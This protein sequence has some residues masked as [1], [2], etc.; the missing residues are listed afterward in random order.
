MKKLLWITA[1]FMAL[2]LV[3]TGCEKEAKEGNP[4]SDDE[5]NLKEVFT[6]VAVDAVE[7]T[8]T[9]TVGA[10]TFSFSGT[11]GQETNWKDELA[12]AT[13]TGKLSVPEGKPF[14]ASKYTGF[15]FEFK[16]NSQW[17]IIIV[18]DLKGGDDNNVWIYKY[19]NSDG[20]GA[21]PK[22]DDWKAFQVDF[23]TPGFGKA[24]GEGKST[25]F[26][27]ALIYELMFGLTDDIA[28]KSFEL[29]NFKVTE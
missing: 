2:A 12:F 10:D 4:P 27:K 11:V 8:G 13:L 22:E 26:N 3:F 6:T 18:N 9:V 5:V 24:W 23:K 20:W 21:I 7:G 19:N 16:T 17:Q 29:R 1:L 15:S 25:A 28:E 14:D